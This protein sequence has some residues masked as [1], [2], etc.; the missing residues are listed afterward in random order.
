MEEMQRGWHPTGKVLGNVVGGIIG[1]LGEEE[2]RGQTEEM[3][4]SSRSI[5]PGYL[6]MYGGE[7]RGQTEEMQRSWHPTCK[8]LGNV[9]GGIVGKLGEEERRGQTEEMERS[10]RS[11][12]PGYHLFG[13]ENREETNMIREG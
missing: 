12:D 13:H 8:V 3:Q 6:P 9:V 7:K 4:R 1:K 10:S 5:D 11:Q 2:R